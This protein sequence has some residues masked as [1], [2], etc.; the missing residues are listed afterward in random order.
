MLSDL[1]K[2]SG[3]LLRN[4]GPAALASGIQRFGCVRLRNLRRPID[5]RLS[6]VAYTPEQPEMRLMNEGWD[7]AILLD[8]CRY[9]LFEEFNTLGGRLESRVSP[10]SETSEFLTV[11]F[12]GSQYHDTVYVTANPMYR[13]LAVGAAFHDV[14][15]VW[16]TDWNE[17]FQTVLPEATADAALAAYDDYPNKRLLVHFLQPHYP[18]IGELREQL[19]SHAGA[20]A[21]YQ[22]AT[23]E[24]Q[25]RRD[26]P[27]IWQL[28]EDGAVSDELA[29]AGYKEN[30]EL[31]L[32]DVRR[33]VRE[34]PGWTVVTSDH[35]NLLGERVHPFGKRMYGHPSRIRHEHLCRVPWLV[36][37][38]SDRRR[39]IE[40]R[41]HDRTS[42]M[43]QE[44]AERLTNLGYVDPS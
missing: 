3:T 16:E 10:A 34:I 6:R 23:G 36:I 32:P 8:G 13:T 15:D 12:G 24:R 9:D 2:K 40:E 30:L 39:L 42:E 7:T 4:G 26:N 14:I 5:A 35:G 43:T 11:N 38:S 33:L 18:F 29:W 31:A 1:L 22:Q 21:T 19:P 37:D 25:A 41:P 44:V 28:L 17:E 20:E 27:T